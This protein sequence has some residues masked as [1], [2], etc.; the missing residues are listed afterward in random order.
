MR[1]AAINR[2][3]ENMGQAILLIMSNI[4]Q[5]VQAHI[6]RADSVERIGSSQMSN[7]INF[8]TAVKSP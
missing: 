8:P 2:V 1:I 3:K 5:S 6:K 4:R 7:P